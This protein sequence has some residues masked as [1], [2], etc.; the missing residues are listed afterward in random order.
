MSKLTQQSIPTDALGAAKPSG[1]K[2]PLAACEILAP[3]DAAEH[4]R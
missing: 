3:G 4:N 1:W 2:N